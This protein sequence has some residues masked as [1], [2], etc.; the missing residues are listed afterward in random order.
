M[1]LKTWEKDI[2]VLQREGDVQRIRTNNKIAEIGHCDMRKEKENQ[3]EENR[4]TRKAMDGRSGGGGE[5]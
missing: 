3:M 1:R 2:F 5:D 4:G